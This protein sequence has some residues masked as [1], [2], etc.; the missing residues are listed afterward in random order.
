MEIF[1]NKE[2]HFLQAIQ[3]WQWYPITSPLHNMYKDHYTLGFPLNPIICLHYIGYVSYMSP[4]QG[5]E[6]TC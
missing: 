1:T 3:D 5:E 2:K 6:K 4:F